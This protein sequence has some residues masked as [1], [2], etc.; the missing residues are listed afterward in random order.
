MLSS[1]ATEMI[2]AASMLPN[3]RRSNYGLTVIMRDL[4]SSQDVYFLLGHNIDPI[5]IT[6]PGTTSIPSVGRLHGY[7]T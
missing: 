1:V 4:S 5:H 2:A 7:H 6:V 3:S